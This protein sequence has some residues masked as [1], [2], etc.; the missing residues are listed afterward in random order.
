MKKLMLLFVL[1]LLFFSEV[2]AEG[3][4]IDAEQAIAIDVRTGKIL[5]EKNADERVP[6]ANLSRLMTIYL[7]Y[8][9]VADGK[10]KWT[11]QVAIS[12]YAYNL[13][14][15]PEVTNIPL[16][17]DSYT[18]EDL[19]KASI[20]SASSSATIALAEHVAGSEEDFVN[21]MIK[22]AQKWQLDSPVFVN[23][24]GLN[25]RHIIGHTYPDT[26]PDD[27]NQMT[28]RDL[29]IVSRHLL[30][31]FPEVMD[32][33]KATRGNFADSYI[34]TYNYLLENMPYARPD[35]Y[36]LITGSSELS[37]SSLI[38]LTYENRMQV[39]TVIINANGGADDPYKRFQVANDFLDQLG[40]EFHLQKVLGNQSSFKDKKAPV[41]DGK[42]NQVDAVA[43]DDFYVVTTPDTVDKVKLKV[44]FSD[45]PNYAPIREEQ[46]VG[47]V[48]FD[49]QVLVGQGY[50]EELPSMALIADQSVERSNFLKVMWNHFVRYV[51]ENL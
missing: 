18:L 4:S 28:A 17:E 38:S 19:T 46:V 22:L 43:Q 30:L 2:K 20:I 49:D 29:A 47:K 26:K 25:N 31:D 6:V 7:T 40:Q 3:L 13:T 12:D 24:S 9:A 51:I 48:V 15:N 33:T 27:E 8:Q 39:L 50:L 10:V 32:F 16:E 41:L 23:A 44:D 34:Y 45:H 1:P 5:Y 37:G 11:D 21:Q 14:Y 35:A 42:A 36:G